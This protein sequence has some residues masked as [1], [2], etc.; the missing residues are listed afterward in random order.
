MTTT[1]LKNL[2]ILTENVNRDLIFGDILL[3]NDKIVSVGKYSGDADN[4][5]DYSGD[6]VSPGFINTHAHV[7]MSQMKAI[8]DDVSF[9]DFLSTTF[10]Y[11]AERTEKDV[12]EGAILGIKE[13]LLGGITTFADLYYSED[14]IANIAERYNIR[15][16]AAWAVLDQEYTTQKGN[17]IDNCRRFME[18]I[19][20][21]KHELVTPSVGV[22]GVYVASEET[23]HKAREL[24]DKYGSYVHMHLSETRR[25]VNEHIKKTGLRPVEWL[26]RIEFLNSS[27]V[28]AHSV[29]LTDREIDIFA[30]KN[31]RVSHCPTSNMKLAT[32]GIAPIPEMR[33]KHVKTSIGTDSVVSNNS[34]NMLSEMKLTAILHKYS[35]WNAEVMKAQE[36]L[37]MA[38]IEGAEV[39]NSDHIIGSVEPGKK[40]DLIFFNSKNVAFQPFDASRIISNLVYASDRSAIRDVMV[41][42]KYSVKNGKLLF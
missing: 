4:T 26:D 1:L 18:R 28:A 30:D 11:D 31:V 14:K 41:N 5:V 2:W 3:E 32:G 15:M 36:V 23:F 37:D 35:K 12:E 21:E 40:A 17:P 39:L 19:K 8:A 33:K 29:W 42:G 9:D 7:A 13:M 25:E 6:I 27:T 34:L 10:R 16:H 38:T 24:A 20:E 22:Q